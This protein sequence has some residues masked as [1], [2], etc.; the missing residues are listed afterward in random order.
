VSTGSQNG[1]PWIDEDPTPKSKSDAL[2]AL[3]EGV[4][5][6]GTKSAKIYLIKDRRIDLPHPPGLKHWENARTGESALLAPLRVGADGDVVAVQAIYLDH[7]GHK[8]TVDPA[9]QRLSIQR[10]PGAAFYLPY[11]GDS[12]DVV[13]AEGLEDALTVWRYGAVRCR[14]A[15]VPGVGVLRHLKFPEGTRVTFIVDGDPPGSKGAELLQ[16]G[17]DAL[18]L[19]GCEVL[20]T[21]TPPEGW[22]ANRFL[23]ERGV[24]TLQ[25]FVASAQPAKLSDDGRIRELAKLDLLAWGRERKK[26]A[27]EL[28]IPVGI[29]D[30]IVDKERQK[31]AEEAKAEQDDWVGVDDTRPWS[32]EVDGAELL[33]DLEST[34]HRFVIMSKEAARAVALWVVFTWVFDAA[35]SALKLWIKSAEKRSGKT[36]LIEVLS[37]IVKRPL[38]GSRMTPAAFFRLIETKHPTVLLDEFDTFAAQDENFRGVLNAGFDKRFSTVWVCAGDDKVP[39]PFALWTPQVIS[40]IGDIP[41]TVAD[42]SMKIELERKLRSQKVAKLR[43]RATGTLEVLAQKCARWAEDNI[44]D[45]L[46]AEPEVPE[47]IN[48]RAADGWELLIAIADQVSGRW[49][50]RARQAAIMLAGDGEYPIDD[51]SIGIQLLHD[52]RAVLNDRSPIGDTPAVQ[53]KVSSANL[54]AWLVALEDRPWIEFKRGQ[55]MTQHQLAVRLRKFHITPTTKKSDGVTFKGYSENCFQTGLRPL[56]TATLS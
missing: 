55:P 23:I 39:T 10:A 34:L 22:D 54:A 24:E 21:A 32:E 17:L 25:M 28:G 42:R 40:G 9:K 37:Y 2:R 56:P 36:R 12:K 19:Q 52:I 20:V 43:R 26:A 33:D 45:L 16:K 3:R 46:E 47:S 49:P 6:A 11:D 8:S 38:T 4:D 5:I 51:E 41:D 31:L 48:D 44:S 30:R 27:E 7:E 50:Q 18:I 1:T 15:G 14:V 29:L 35:Y 13:V 53:D